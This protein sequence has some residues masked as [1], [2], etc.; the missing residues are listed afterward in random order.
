MNHYYALERNDAEYWAN[1]KRHSYVIYRF[2]NAEVKQPSR[3][4]FPQKKYKI[5]QREFPK[6]QRNEKWKYKN[7][8]KRKPKLRI[9]QPR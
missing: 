6:N 8:M 9:D 2:E 3:I 7:K 4:P 1:Q 5:L